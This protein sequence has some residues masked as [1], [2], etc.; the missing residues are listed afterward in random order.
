MKLPDHYQLAIKAYL[1]DPAD[2]QKKLG[3]NGAY[4]TTV[5]DETLNAIRDKKD[6]QAFLIE[7]GDFFNAGIIK[8]LYPKFDELR[9]LIKQ[10]QGVASYCTILDFTDWLKDTI[11]K[12]NKADLKGELEHEIKII[13]MQSRHLLDELRALQESRRESVVAKLQEVAAG[14]GIN[15]AAFK[16][17]DAMIETDARHLD[18]LRFKRDVS[19]GVFFSVQQ[20][21]DNIQRESQ[22][23]KEIAALDAVVSSVRS[24]DFML[25]VKGLSNK[26]IDM[27]NRI[28]DGDDLL[29][30]KEAAVADIAAKQKSLSPLEVESRMREEIEYVRDLVMLAAKRHHMEACPFLKH[31]EVPF[32][33]KEVI[34]C[35]DRILEFD[36]AIF[37]NDR[38]ALFGKPSIVL[39]PGV[40]NAL[41]DWKNN[42]IVIPL[43]PAMPGN[44][45]ASFAA[46][47]IEYRLDVDEDKVI[48]TSYNKIS[49]Y[50]DIKSVFQLRANLTKDYIAWM[51]SEYKGY[52]VLSQNVKKWFD[53]EIAP[54]RNE[55][56]TPPPYRKFVLTTTEYQNLLKSTDER[57]VEKGEGCATADLWVASVLHY[58][59]GKFERSIELLKQLLK[60]EPDHVF[61][62]YNL[63]Q[64][65]AKS[66]HKQEAIAAFLEFSKLNPQSWWAAV[67]RDQVRQLQK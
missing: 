24:K 65:C 27:F 59:S 25:S 44:F 35:L 29:K 1:S 42:Q 56:F 9:L 57:I 4:W 8:E 39:V 14:A 64:T 53:R 12:V 19:H 22:V 7:A 63:G 66:M 6:I 31:D 60:R 46:G 28:L 36:P 47:F 32:T 48:I 20:K 67:A 17:I 52:R 49:E 55:V 23:Q 62:Y 30:K 16:T 10:G 51:T 33:A 2:P 54:D 43:I 34:T 3:L 58:Q 45:I 5:I 26:I 41:F 18:C 61:A 50:E 40:G 11:S 13:C 21:R 37:H 38:V 15:G